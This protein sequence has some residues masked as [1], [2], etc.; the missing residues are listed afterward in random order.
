[1][2]KICIILLTILST[3]ISYGQQKGQ[4]KKGVFVIENSFYTFVDRGIKLTG[5]V[6]EFTIRTKK[7]KVVID[8]VWFGATPVKCDIYQNGNRLMSDTLQSAGM[9]TV[10]ANKDLYKNFYPASDSTEAYKKFKPPFAFRSQAAIF[11][12]FKGK[13]YYETVCG[14]PQHEA[15]P[16]RD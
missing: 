10:K 6:Y 13:R 8:S 14:I 4:T 7:P 12:F 5:N 16:L 15:K 9:Y 11:Y 1:M 2:K 3:S